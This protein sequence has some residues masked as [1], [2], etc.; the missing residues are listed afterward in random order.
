MDKKLIKLLFLFTNL[1][2]YEMPEDGSGAR[3]GGS[4]VRLISLLSY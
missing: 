2:C 1:I 4:G 3:S